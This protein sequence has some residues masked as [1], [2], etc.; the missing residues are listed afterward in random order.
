MIV[1]PGSHNKFVA[2]DSQQRIARCITTLSGELVAALTGHTVLA[3]TLEGSFA[4]SI[5]PDWLLRGARLAREQGLAR[6][7][8]AV[9]AVGLFAGASRDQCAN[10][11]LGAVLAGD[12]QA[13]AAGLLHELPGDAPVLVAGEP[14]A[15]AFTCVAAD[16]PRTATRVRAVDAAY[17]SHLAGW[18]A[19]RVAAQRGLIEL[20]P[21]VKSRA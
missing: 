10:V 4:K 20:A 9:R 15:S 7:A 11:L 21:A 3:A 8:F 13:L 16:D 5:D 1:L 2:L 12:V 6:A 14:L 19:L 17:A 18:G